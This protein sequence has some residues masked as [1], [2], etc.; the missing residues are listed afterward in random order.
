MN[1]KQRGESDPVRNGWDLK[2]LLL[3][4]N[5]LRNN[6]WQHAHCQ[7]API[8]G[9]YQSL[10]S[11]ISRRS[12]DSI[13]SR[14]PTGSLLRPGG[15]QIL[16]PFGRELSYFASVKQ[17]AYLHV[18]AGETTGS[19]CEHEYSPL[20]D[21]EDYEASSRKMEGTRACSRAPTVS[22][23]PRGTN[24][25]SNLNGFLCI[26][27]CLKMWIIVFTHTCAPVLLP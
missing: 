25:E 13:S 27:A 20:D 5:T 7:L 14:L 11:V 18:F 10:P 21:T 22:K 8:N 4:Q 9:C 16:R 1:G 6:S 2:P 3:G 12:G 23:L 26:F 19:T 24:T 17:G 15:R